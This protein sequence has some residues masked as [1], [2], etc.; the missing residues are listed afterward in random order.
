MSFLPISPASTTH[1]VTT[2][3]APY[4]A[5]WP[6][7]FFA[8]LPWVQP[9]HLSPSVSAAPLLI[10]WLCTALLL[11]WGDWRPSRSAS[12]MS[13]GGIALGLLIAT[14]VAFQMGAGPEG[15]GLL[16]A[17]AV[18]AACIFRFAGANAI[19]ISA[20]IRAWWLAGVLSALMGLVQYAG[21]SDHFAPWVSYNAGGEAYANLRQ[22]NLYASLTSIA[23]CALVWLAGHDKRFQHPA[24]AAGWAVLLA[25][26]N[27]L[28]H[29]RTGL[30]ELIL[31]VGL[32]WWWG[33]HKVR[34]VRWT[35]VAVL[36]AYLVISAGTPWLFSTGS[37]ENMLTRLTD[38]TPSCMSRVALWANVLELIQLR[39]WFGWGWGELDY[40]HFITPYTGP[41][42]CAI[43]DN[44]HNLPLHLAVELGVPA[45]LLVCAGI[46]WGVLRLRPWAETQAHRQLAWSV[47]AV[48]GLHSLLEYPL[49]YGPFQLALGICGALLWSPSVVTRPSL[50]K[51]QR[52]LRGLLSA[53]LLIGLI[54]V[55]QDYH[56]MRQIYLAPE[57]RDPAYAQDTIGQLQT[58]QL[59]K[60]QARF[61]ELTLQPLT[62]ANAAWTYATA[63]QLLHFSPEYRVVE[64]V[65]ES[66]VMLGYDEQAQFYLAR[67]RAV[68]P[69]EHTQ[70]SQNLRADSPTTSEDDD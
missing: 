50:L 20:L 17:L 55:G 28:S 44:A 14:A 35:L 38:G 11:L 36:P 61:A 59:F 56:H 69:Q 16:V 3:I 68:F 6:L 43:L 29:S 64:K 31:I 47:L 58:V 4:W 18:V 25:G 42:F 34:A 12:A 5:A 67:Y 23:L 37:D 13:A 63:T 33:L 66:A 26:G 22:R 41:R 27:A 2:S 62:Q 32:S 48:L 60:D 8:T 39:P 15:L 51:L 7:V 52:P 45:A 30:F 1:P 19:D 54:A 24:W 49:W 70:W 9:W 57:Q 46:V 40:A 65:I 10:S 21:W 53:L